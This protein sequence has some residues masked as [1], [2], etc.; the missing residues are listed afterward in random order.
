MVA[1]HGQVTTPSV[2]TLPL[3]E[4]AHQINATARLDMKNPD[5][6]AA[7][8]Q[9]RFAVGQPPVVHVRTHTVHHE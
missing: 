9:W 3:P 8:I 6:E 4:G 2:V 1:R 5:V 7:T